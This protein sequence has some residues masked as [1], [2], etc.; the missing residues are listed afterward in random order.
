LFSLKGKIE[1]GHIQDKVVEV[2]KEKEGKQR[3]IN[4]INVLNKSTTNS[5]Q[6]SR[7]N[8]IVD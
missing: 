3:E 7:R 2:R 4:I 5:G 1:S 8:M 6:I